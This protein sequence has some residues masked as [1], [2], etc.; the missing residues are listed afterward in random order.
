MTGA[1]GP[2]TTESLCFSVSY[3]ATLRSVAVQSSLR[4]P[5]RIDVPTASR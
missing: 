1:K 5:T 3:P 4:T 2:L